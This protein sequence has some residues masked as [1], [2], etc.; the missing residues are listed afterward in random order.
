MGLVC[1]G[2]TTCPVLTRCIVSEVRMTAEL[3]FRPG[4]KPAV[5]A[6]EELCKNFTTDPQAFVS[7]QLASPSRAEYSIDMALYGP[8]LYPGADFRGLSEV[9]YRSA[10]KAPQSVVTLVHKSVR[11]LNVISTPPGDAMLNIG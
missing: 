2:Q 5:L 4:G 1:E 10:Q 6:G 8:A 7:R 9:V 3:V 11:A